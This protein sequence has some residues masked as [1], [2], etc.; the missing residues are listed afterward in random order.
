MSRLGNLGARLYRGEVGYDFIRNRKIWY[1]VSILITIT[2]IIGVAVG[3]LRMG[4]EFKGGAVFTTDSRA[5]I[6]TSEATD[7]ATEASGRL[8]IVQELGNGG[9]RIQITEVDTAKANGIKETLSEELGI[10]A[11]EIN[12]D[13]VGPSWGEQI[14][15]KAWTGL[16]IFMVLVVIYLAK[17]SSGG[18]PSPPSSP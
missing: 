3:G 11:E 1:G 9:L 12:A 18:W 10:P 13:L 6:S 7:V 16:G 2:A 8:A 15:N 17:P 5:Q 4:I 14:A